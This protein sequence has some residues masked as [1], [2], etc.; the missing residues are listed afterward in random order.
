MTRIQS[1]PLLITYES[2]ASALLATL[3][4]VES[5]AVHTPYPRGD[6]VALVCDRLQL[7]PSMFP[8]SSLEIQR[9]VFRCGALLGADRALD[10]L[11]EELYDSDSD[12]ESD[13][14]NDVNANDM[15]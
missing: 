7:D 14:E 10:R 5:V 3:L 9:L 8:T 13:G 6:A 12:P 15:I 4:K 11:H 1:H 2:P